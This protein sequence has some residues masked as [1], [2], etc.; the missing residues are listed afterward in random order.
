MF[1][2]NIYHFER[3]F[4]FFNKI[5]NGLWKQANNKVTSSACDE[6]KNIQHKL[7][8]G[9]NQSKIFSHKLGHQKD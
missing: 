4:W 3:I 9:H 2:S 7:Q 1:N 5:Y 6:N 8:Q